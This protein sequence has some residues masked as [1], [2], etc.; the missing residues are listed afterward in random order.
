MPAPSM[1]H[2][3]AAPAWGRLDKDFG[4]YIVMLAGA[5]IANRRFFQ[6]EQDQGALVGGVG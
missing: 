2:Y 3:D 5:C 1:V 6:Q 4:G